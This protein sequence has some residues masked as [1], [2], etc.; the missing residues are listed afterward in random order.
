MASKGK[1][2]Q[3]QA[4]RPVGRQSM[5]TESPESG[6][7]QLYKKKADCMVCFLFAIIAHYK[8]RRNEALKMPNLTTQ[9]RALANAAHRFDQH[10]TPCLRIPYVSFTENLCRKVCKNESKSSVL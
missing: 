3:R 5:Q 10:G 7:G 8:K 2:E 4:N 9:R 1:G 6:G